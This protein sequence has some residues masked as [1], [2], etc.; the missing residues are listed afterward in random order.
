MKI[1]VLV[2]W[3]VTPCR[4]VRRYQRFGGTYCLHLQPWTWSSMLL[5]KV[6]LCP[7]VSVLTWNAQIPYPRGCIK[8]EESL[9][10]LITFHLLSRW[11]W[12]NNQTRVST[13][14]V[15]W[16]HKD[17]PHD[18]PHSVKLRKYRHVRCEVSTEHPGF[19]PR[20]QPPSS[21]P[22]LCLHFSPLWLPYTGGEQLIAR[23]PSSLFSTC[24]G[25]F[26]VFPTS[27][28]RFVSHQND[29]RASQIDVLH[30]TLL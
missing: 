18:K 9:Y 16:K 5:R 25:S 4:L 17:K 6:Y 19:N 27:I 13:Q 2:F 22:Q 24:T 1:R 11:N 21:V 12:R 3:V 20:T 29:V 8:Q 26:M 23:A 28:S 15:R 14:W 7:Y 30:I 10:K